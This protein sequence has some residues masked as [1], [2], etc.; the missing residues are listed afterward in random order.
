MR[1]IGEYVRLYFLIEAQYIKAQMQYRA[2]F[3][4]S[5]I[6]MFFNSLVTLSVFLVLFNTIPSLA[7]WS[8]MEMVFI[9]AFYLLA[10]SPMQI[11][12]DNIW[13]L[14]FQTQSGEFLKY[15]FRP[16][17]MLFYFMSDRFDIKGLTQLAAGVILLVYASVQ[18]QLEWSAGK[19]LLL[20]IAMFGGSLVVIAINVTAGS[21]AFWVV[22]SYPMLA[23]TWRMREF[24]P[25]PITIF[26]GVFRF[27][28]TFVLP[29][30]FIAFYPAQFFLRPD[31][32]SPW[33][34]LSPF[35]GIAL[36][37]LM[38]RVWTM[39]VNNYTGTGS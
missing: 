27:V 24:A 18:L 29:I 2:D 30:G 9:Y 33:I 4:I 15:Y 36:F 11:F 19:L 16:L 1:S 7:G 23:L 10:L 35:I 6:G 26:D 3:F 39:G 38:Y 34:Y 8:L 12:F 20:L 14:R 28:F 5:S 31:E 37:A 17:N 21:A 25:Y 22:N 13:F 32:I